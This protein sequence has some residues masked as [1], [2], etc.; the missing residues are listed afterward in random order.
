VNRGSTVAVMVKEGPS[1]G[2]VPLTRGMARVTLQDTRPVCEDAHATKEMPGGVGS[3]NTNASPSGSW[4]YTRM[5]VPLR[6][7]MASRP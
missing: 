3:A 4:S 2:S 6:M 1:S 5:V 7:G